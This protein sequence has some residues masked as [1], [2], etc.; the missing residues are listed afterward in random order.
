MTPCLLGPCHDKA[1]KWPKL[2]LRPLVRH[3]VNPMRGKEDA[4][5]TLSLVFQ[6]DGVP[7]TMVTDDSKEQ[8]PEQIGGMTGRWGESMLCGWGKYPLAADMYWGRVHCVYFAHAVIESMT[9]Q[10]KEHRNETILAREADAA[11]Y[12]GVFEALLVPTDKDIA[13]G[14]D[15]GR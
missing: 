1:T 9:L 7:P 2:M 14:K 10:L 4:H 15:G 6:C 3:C 13:S 11:R 8:T 5:E 12:V